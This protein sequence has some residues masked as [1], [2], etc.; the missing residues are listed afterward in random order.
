MKN[1]HPFEGLL[2]R[3]SKLQMYMEV[4]DA[5]VFY[6]PM[7]LTHITYKANLNCSLLKPILRD[8][9]KNKLVE[10]RIMKNNVVKYAATNAARTTIFRFREITHILPIA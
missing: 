4:L 6:G 8:L 9:V 1:E 2:M 7:R 10:E 3:R 5:L